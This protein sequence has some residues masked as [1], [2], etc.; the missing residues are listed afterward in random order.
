METKETEDNNNEG[1]ITT[2]KNS[3][4]W[5]PLDLTSLILLKLPAKFL[6]EFTCV[7]KTWYSIILSKMFINTFMSMS[8]SRPRLLLTYKCNEN[9]GNELI[10][11]SSPHISQ[12]S[13]D[14]SSVVS[15]MLT[16]DE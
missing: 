7:S 13:N 16:L 4:G 6:V 8:I 15:R 3:L 14:S 2:V 1:V 12:E 9:N 10:F 5:I 11:F